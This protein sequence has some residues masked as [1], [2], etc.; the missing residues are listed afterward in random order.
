MF[1]L[2]FKSKQC[3]KRLEDLL[4]KQKNVFKVIFMED[5]DAQETK[6]SCKC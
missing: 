6:Y 5:R 1:V 2:D 3:F 4:L